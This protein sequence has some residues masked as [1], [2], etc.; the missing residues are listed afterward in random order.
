MGKDTNFSPFTVNLRDKITVFDHPVVMGIV[1]ASSDSFYDGGRYADTP[2]L[3]RHAIDLVENGADIVDLGALSTRPGAVL[4]SAEE[5]AA[6]LSELVRQIRSALPDTPISVDT[7]RSLPARRAIEAGADI[8]NDIS[9]GLFDD[10][11][12]DTV[13]RLQVPYVLSHNR[14]TPD[15]MMEQTHY[16]DLMGEVIRFLSERLDQLYTLGVKDVWIDP[17]FGFAKTTEQNYELMAHLDELTSLFR[18]PLLAG[19][20][21]K[22]MIYKTL[23]CSPD[24]ALNGT[25]VLN[26]IALMK[27]ARIIRVHDPKEA[28]EAIKIVERLAIN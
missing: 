24:E 13:S 15:R 2:A 26:T 17:G 18:E 19:V 22:S 3:L 10:T 12:F 1:N 9:G 11:L 28:K 21:R 27:G 5:E 23:Q 4:S 20:S 8:V 6:R 14:T 25:T 16:D 7:S